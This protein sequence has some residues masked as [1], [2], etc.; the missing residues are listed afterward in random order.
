MA[1]ALPTPADRPA[2]FPTGLGTGRPLPIQVAPEEEDTWLRGLGA[3]G[4]MGALFLVV[5]R[6]AQVDGERLS[7]QRRSPMFG[8][9][10][11]TW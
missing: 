2:G 8:A 5:V 10:P 3:L 4:I 9:T 11:R 7:A 1:A 6:W